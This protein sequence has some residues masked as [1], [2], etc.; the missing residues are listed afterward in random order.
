VQ[1]MSGVLLVTA[2]IRP[3]NFPGSPNHNPA[4]V[5]PA[6][7]A[8]SQAHELRVPYVGPIGTSAP[9]HT[10]SLLS[11]WQEGRDVHI[12]RCAG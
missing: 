11:A 12:C 5:T 6:F 1:P 3:Q 9:V 2:I 10:F 4:L 8:I 7:T